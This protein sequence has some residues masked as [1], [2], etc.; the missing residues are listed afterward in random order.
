MQQQLTKPKSILDQAQTSEQVELVQS[1]RAGKPISMLVNDENDTLIETIARWRWLLGISASPDKTEFIATIDFIKTNYGTLTI[2]EIILAINLSLK[3]SLDADNKPY[4]VFSA[5]YIS[6]ILNAYLN[7]KDKIY[8]ELAHLN[9]LEYQKSIKNQVDYKPSPDQ[10]AENM[11]EI[12]RDSYVKTC[13]NQ[14]SFFDPFFYIYNFLK[15]KNAFNFSDEEMERINKFSQT[16]GEKT[17][18]EDRYYKKLT[19]F[20]REKTLDSSINSE[21]KKLYCEFFLSQFN[22]I[23][24]F[25]DYFLKTITAKD[26]TNVHP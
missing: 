24:D 16:L 8:R 17:F 1:V 12:L 14:E 23:K 6:N 4:G 26:F 19:N 9:D 18:N 11:K 22:S 5:L 21:K 25:E 20:E 15:K 7:Y 3:G 10:M 13:Q 2:S